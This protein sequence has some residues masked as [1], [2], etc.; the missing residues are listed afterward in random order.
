M[1]Q[2]NVFGGGGFVGSRYCELTP[3]VIKNHRSDYEI[4]SNEVVYFISTID[5]YNVHTDPYLDIDT[6]LTTFIKVL[7]THR[8]ENIPDLTFNFISSWFVYGGVDLP[9]REDAHCD[10]KGF[11]S[12]TKRAAE[13]LLASYCETFG[14]KYRI[15]RLPNVLGPQDNKVSKKKNALQ[16]MINEIKNNRPVQLYDGGR[17]Y[18]DYMYVD[19]VVD[20]INTVIKRG[21]VN[22][23]YNIGRGVPVWLDEVIESVVQRTGSTSTITNIPPAEFHTKVQTTNMVLDVNKL[24]RLGFNPKYTMNDMLDIL[25]K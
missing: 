16:Y 24:H 20:A 2:V 7:E 19:D 22:E 8:N 12:I 3:N 23:I 18:R 17:C 14:I 4:K 9:A 5:N 13:Q 1:G 6:N 11:Y 21:D 15:L 10:P 25:C